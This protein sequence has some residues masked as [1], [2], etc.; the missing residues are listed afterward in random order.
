MTDEIRRVL[1]DWF[2]SPDG[3]EARQERIRGRI[4]AL[5]EKEEPVRKRPFTRVLALALVSML[6][7]GTG[8]AAGLSLN[9][10]NYFSDRAHENDFDWA[11]EKLDSL[12]DKNTLVSTSVISLPQGMSADDITQIHT[13]YYDGEV[14]FVGYAENWS[15]PTVEWTPTE[16]ERA[17]YALPSAIRT[18]DY[19]P[20][21]HAAEALIERAMEAGQPVGF[22]QYHRLSR[23]ANSLQTTDGK[24]LWYTFG[25]GSDFNASPD[26][27]QFQLYAMTQ[28]MSPLP[29]EIRGKD[30]IEVQLP[31]RFETICYWFDGR[32]LYIWDGDYEQ[33]MLS[34][35]IDRDRDA[36]HGRYE[37]VTV[38]L[39]GTETT[40]EAE[41]SSYLLHVK[42]SADEPIFVLTDVEPWKWSVYDDAGRELIKSFSRSYGATPFR[43]DIREYSGDG[44]YTETWLWLYGE[45]PETL[46]LEIGQDYKK[47]EA[48]VTLRLAE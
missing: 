1:K 47:D 34:A 40:V 39:D 23:A 6:L 19:K 10:F 21:N 2:A 27:E 9:I 12:R 16:E 28:F 32:E 17:L 41:A 20:L 37:P 11:Q 18:K 43:T 48:T 35:V 5:E 3:S 25:T 7:V 29:D 42:L 15:I 36:R 8:L 33:A 24:R 26:D 30:R 14:L 22:K 4:A 13:A 31:I 46:T 44:L 45:I 38:M